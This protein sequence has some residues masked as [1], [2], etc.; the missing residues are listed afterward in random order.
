MNQLLIDPKPIISASSKTTGKKRQYFTLASMSSFLAACRIEILPTLTPAPELLNVTGEITR[1]N[2]VIT[3]GSEGS[4]GIVDALAGD[5]AITGGDEADFIRGNAGADVINSGAGVDNIVVVGVTNNAGYTPSDIQNPNGS[6]I[7]LSNVINLADLNNN[8]ISDLQAGEI[9]D[10]GVDGAILFVYGRADFSAVMLSN[11]SRIDMQAEVIFTAA[12]LKKMIDDGTLKN[13]IGDGRTKLIITND[14]TS[15][16]LD[17]T[18]IDVRNVCQFII[19][20]EVT[21]VLDQDDLRGMC[22]I[23]GAGNVKAATGELDL[24]GIQISN[25][26]GILGGN[27]N[28]D[29]IVFPTS[30]PLPTPFINSQPMGSIDI[31]AIA[32]YGVTLTAD[33]SELSDADGLGILHYQWKSGT[34]N[35]GTDSDAYTPVSSDLGKVITLVVSY[36]DLLGH[37]ESMT[38]N[39]LTVPANNAPAGA[40]DI[41]SS[42]HKGVALTA[43]TSSLGDGDGLGTLHYQWKSGTDNVGVDSDTYTPTIGD[44]GKDITVVVTYSDGKGSA[45]SITS[46]ANVV[47]VSG[48][49]K[50][51][52]LNSTNGFKLNG[53]A[54]NDE[55]GRSVSAAGDVNGDGYDD[56]IIGAYRADPNAQNNSG[57]SY[58]VYGKATGTSTTVD[59]S[60]ISGGDGSLGFRVDGENSG[61]ESG[62]SVSAA[63]DVNGDGYDDFIIGAY[64]ADP[65]G[66]INSG[67]SYV[68]Y[69]RASAAG[70]II[71]LS[72]IG[73]G[74]GSLG[75]RLD[76]EVA[77][78]RSGI[79][80]RSA[81]DLNSDGY[82]DF[83]IGAYYADS[84]GILNN[85]S[86]Y[87]I[88]GKASGTSGTINLSSI[89]GGDG[90]LGF[91]LDGE[92][93]ADRSGA[94]VAS[95][96]DVNGD[97]YDDL[98][99]G[100]IDSSSSYIVYG[101]AAGA[102]AI[103][104]L[105]AISGGDGSLGFRLDSETT[106][107][108]S[109]RT[110]SAAGDVNGD[111]YDDLIIGA[112]QADYD[113]KGNSGSSYVV[114][115]KATDTSNV[116]NLS[117]ISGGNGSLGFRIDGQSLSDY[118][119][120]SVSSAGDVNGDG[121][122]DLIIGAYQA[123]PNGNK[124]G[125]SYV[126]YGKA[127]GTIGTISLSSISGGDG[128][129]GFRLEGEAE[130]DYSGRS[131][132]SAGDVN[133][134]G[135]DDLIIGA[136]KADTNGSDSGRTYIIYGGAYLEGA[137][138]PIVMGGN[139][140][141]GTSGDDTLTGATSDDVINAALG[142][143]V[144]TGGVGA[145]QLWG[146]GGLDA[147]KF[148]AGD[149]ILTI[150]G[151]GN[152][153]AVK[154][155]DVIHDFKVGNGNFNSETF[156]TVDVASIATTLTGGNASTLTIGNH[157]IQSH[158]IIN[159]VIT[160]DDQA[161]F[162]TALEI[163]TQ[164]SVAAALQ[165]LQ[166]N[167][168]GSAG[169]TLVFDVGA[170]SFIF[171]QG[172]VAGT[173]NLDVVVRLEGVQV[174]N[175]ITSNGTG[176]F[177]LFI[178]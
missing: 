101:K 139:A 23:I 98:I 66:I 41:G 163:S 90:S 148:V 59:L 63:G 74:D 129:L 140:I 146:G 118:S 94:S 28:N 84:N 89:S 4:V 106:A 30:T 124:S 173:D 117:S 83:I 77:N 79:S 76:G 16:E 112:T 174:D 164:S 71:N 82:D 105:W 171:T 34:N 3:L 155:Y 87:V 123:D 56:F 36:N 107:D 65:N 48:S 161:N 1:G 103:I 86:S 99:I 54:E 162:A 158:S 78:D 81:G 42:A 152:A 93:G 18:K 126:V 166:A 49:L 35:V 40:I 142:A 38:S 134:D 22:E 131:V 172:N 70:G 5:D 11:I 6:G 8:A 115:G 104:N 57:S 61:D 170:D 39:L 37:D 33:V 143:D 130:R 58:V 69:G 21:V 132:R 144:I 109:G 119:G 45:E 64:Y 24:K 53:E 138:H 88:Y 116:I 10:G 125:S 9:I 165:Y 25:N 51:S 50:L 133:G 67:S 111:G 135:Y 85:G 145:D 43:N 68:V 62:V 154:G 108:Y 147:F 44:E 17:F 20:A 31:G 19:P 47:K 156:D 167:D 29:N 14:G 151:F 114:Y 75:F 175:L 92:V 95:A 157:K 150:S 159:G 73:G 127:T 121:Y 168:L 122:D 141:I 60:T 80:T 32:K 169:A 26:I 55:S 2:D 153:G 160:F 100:T 72:A 96:G 178:L 137:A 7:D 91:R 15:I 176:M 120:V 102:S 149:S 110:V 27:D 13:I 46:N 52:S 177:D 97:G 113:G 136:F 128:S 12:Q